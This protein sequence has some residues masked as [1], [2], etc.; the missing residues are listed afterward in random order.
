MMDGVKIG[1]YTVRNFGEAFIIS[2][3]GANHNGD[4]TLAKKLIDLSKKAGA[5]AVKFQAWKKK[6]LFAKIFYKNDPVLEKQLDEWSINYDDLSK[7]RTYSR[8]KNILFGCTPETKSD[9]DFLVNELDVDYIKIASGDLNDSFLIRRVANT[10]KPIILSTGMATLCEIDRT[11]K[12]FEKANNKKLILLHTV[13]LYPPSYDEINLMNIKFFREIYDYPIGYSDHSI[14]ITVPLA[15]VSMGAAMIEKHFTIDK[16][17]PGW[18]HKISADFEDL[19]SLVMQSK[20]IFRSFGELKRKLSMREIKKRRFMR[21][22]IVA[23]RY[24]KKGEKISMDDIVLKRPGTGIPP[25]YL[26]IVVCSK[27]KK[28]IKEDELLHFEDLEVM[29]CE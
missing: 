11:I 15:A 5:D 17:M 1:K 19:R 3:I 27:A 23:S 8:K 2:E 16:S 7:L 4:L 28:D 13:S 29:S 9:V 20:I 22:S 10:E 12:I 14:G 6:T 21:K 25:E 24:I 26:D 18:D